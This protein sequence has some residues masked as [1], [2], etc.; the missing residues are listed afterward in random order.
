MFTF[1][2]IRMLDQACM[3]SV[4]GGVVSTSDA[5]R[6]TLRMRCVFLSMAASSEISCTHAHTH[7]HTHTQ[8]ER[9]SK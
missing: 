8:R 6:L 7:T 5:I 4:S 9:E 2:S 1:D 3:V